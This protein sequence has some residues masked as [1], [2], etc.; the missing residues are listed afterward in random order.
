M[1]KRSDGASCAHKN[2]LPD[3]SL[4]VP[5]TPGSP[6]AAI[7]GVALVRQ[8]QP[9]GHGAKLPEHID[10]NAAP[11]EPIAANAQID[12]LDQIGDALADRDGRVFVKG[13]D[14]AEAREIKLE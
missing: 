4:I 10:G 7:G 12:R 2:S 1:P 11:R 8:P 3:I 14:I 6:A 13:A 5:S 9:F